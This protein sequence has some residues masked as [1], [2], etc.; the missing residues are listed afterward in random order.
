MARPGPG[1]GRTGEPMAKEKDPV[2]GMWVDTDRPAA[3]GQYE[4]KTVY[5]CSEGCRRTYEKSHRPG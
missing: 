3:K 1:A 5:F 2:C 4:G